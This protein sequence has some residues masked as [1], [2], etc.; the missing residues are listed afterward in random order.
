MVSALKVFEWQ[1]GHSADGV[2]VREYG[3]EAGEVEASM[4]ESERLSA[5]IIIKFMF[6]SYLHSRFIIP[7]LICDLSNTSIQPVVPLIA[8]YSTARTASAVRLL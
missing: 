8:G 4:R 5:S 6:S 7:M 3:S 1:G 2:G